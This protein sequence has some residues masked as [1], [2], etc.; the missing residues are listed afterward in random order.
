MAICVIWGPRRCNAGNMGVGQ[1]DTINRSTD[2]KGWNAWHNASF[3]GNVDVMREIR[4][5][6][7]ETLSTEVIKNEMLLRTDREGWN[8][9]HK[10]SIRDNVDVM[11]EI[12]ELAK[13]TL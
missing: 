13:E 3:R 12:R 10:A 9:W 7:K 6:A 11:R 8:A 4:E 2:S 5:L 1:R